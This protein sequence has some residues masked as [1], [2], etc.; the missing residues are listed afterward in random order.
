MGSF[1][2]QRRV[3]DGIEC[4]EVSTHGDHFGRQFSAFNAYIDGRSIEEHY[5]VGIKG[6]SS[7]RAGKGR[8]PISDMTRE[9]LYEEYLSLWRKWASQN[10]SKIRDLQKVANEKGGLLTDCFAST[11]INQA[12][13]L[14]DL[15]NEK[16][17]STV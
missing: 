10:V 7:I 17:W 5:Q 15:L 12:R 11:P 14:A 13:A 9:E 4:V 6:Y 8:P 2:W 1:R 3:P 16:D